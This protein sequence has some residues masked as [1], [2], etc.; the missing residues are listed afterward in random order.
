MQFRATPF[1][2]STMVL[3]AFALWVMYLRFKK[4]NESNIPLFYC[5][6]MV[7]YANAYDTPLSPMLVYITLALALLTR[8]EFMNNGFSKFIGLL[9]ICSLCAIVYYNLTTILVW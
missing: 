1:S 6:I 9:E 8:F 2:V 3:I 4:Q 7:Y 5:A